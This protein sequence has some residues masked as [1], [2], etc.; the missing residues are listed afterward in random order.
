MRTQAL[1]FM[2]LL[3]LLYCRSGCRLGLMFLSLFVYIRPSLLYL[4]GFQLFALQPKFIKTTSVICANRINL[5]RLKWS[6]DSLVIAAKGFLKPPN[7][8]MLP[9]PKNLSLPKNVTLVTF[10]KLIS[11]LNLSKF[12]MPL[13]SNGPE[14]LPSATDKVVCWKL[15]YELSYWKIRHLFKSFPF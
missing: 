1:N 2:L 8:L 4:L 10:G 11:A 15:F 12:F 9:K 13:V 7:F 6:S 14:V 3:L 5:L